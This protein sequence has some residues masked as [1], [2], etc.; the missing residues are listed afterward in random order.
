MHI[1]TFI[2]TSTV[3]HNKFIQIHPIFGEMHITL[4]TEL[5]Y[6]HGMFILLICILETLLFL[7]KYNIILRS[8]L[9][10]HLRKSISRYSPVFVVDLF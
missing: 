6:T 10:L 8:Q 1:C 4:P 3:L 2:V 5:G 9:N 7:F